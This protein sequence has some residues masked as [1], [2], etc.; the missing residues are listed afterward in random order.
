MY[1]FLYIYIYICK[2]AIYTYKTTL[3]PPRGD[4][5]EGDESPQVGRAG[6]VA[7]GGSPRVGRPGWVARAGRQGG[8]LATHPGTDRQ[9]DKQT[10]KQTENSQTGTP[11]SPT[12]PR[13]KYGHSA[14]TRRYSISARP[15]Q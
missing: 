15:Y 14:P 9:T 3:H 8:S 1:I 7:W 13:V 6:W 10:N 2:E 5:N 11:P 12:R 4:K